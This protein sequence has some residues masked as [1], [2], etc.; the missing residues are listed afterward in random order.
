[1][2]ISSLEK[3]LQVVK[4]KSLSRAADNLFITQQ[5]LSRTI[6]ALEEEL[7]APLFRRVRT[8]ME[9]TEYG[10]MIYQN[11]NR[12]IME[13]KSI[14][15]KIRLMNITKNKN[16][17]IA[18]EVGTLSL[19]TYGLFLQFRKQYPDAVITLRE[20]PS[21]TCREMLLSEEA[22]V[23]LS[24]ASHGGNPH[25]SYFP[26]IPLEGAVLIHED[27]PLSQKE[28][29]TIEDLSRQKLI[30]CGYATHISYSRAFE[31]ADLPM[32]IAFSSIES[33]IS[34]EWLIENRGVCPIIKNNLNRYDLENKRIVVRP[35]RNDIPW[36]VYL[37]TKKDHAFTEATQRFIEFIKGIDWPKHPLAQ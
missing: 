14:L 12:I 15:N 16:V 6:K 35:F 26:C 8:G 24:S 32:H 27:N 21:N 19:L 28:V 4:D 3:F 34:L 30:I 18:V 11:A 10:E 20:R 7:D 31:H 5:G 13:Y 33:K 23:C 36:Y 2:D 17:Y 22:D 29:I 1:M 25:F 9:L 37:I